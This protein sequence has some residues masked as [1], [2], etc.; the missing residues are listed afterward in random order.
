MCKYAF[1]CSIDA[2]SS[3]GLEYAHNAEFRTNL[4][5]YGKGVGQYA[6]DAI[7]QYVAQVR[8]Y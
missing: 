2:F 7:Q 3:I 8:G 4:D 1:D 6:C 5:N